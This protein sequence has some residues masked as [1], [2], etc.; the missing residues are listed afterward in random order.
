MAGEIVVLVEHFEGKVDSVT[1][2]LLAAGR[3]LANQLQ[4]GL[5]ALACGDALAGV[6]AA[7]EGRGMDKIMLV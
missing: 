7:L 2:Q 5:V 3:M 1:F 4:V 6:S